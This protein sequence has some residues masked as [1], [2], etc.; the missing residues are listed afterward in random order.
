[1]APPVLL[2]PGPAPAPTSVPGHGRFQM[3]L[4]PWSP[5]LG[6]LFSVAAVPLLA[7]VKAG[8]LSSVLPDGLDGTPAQAEGGFPELSA[9]RWA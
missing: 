3:L 2:P 4:V 8:S 1:M 9:S 5:G 7:F 6:P